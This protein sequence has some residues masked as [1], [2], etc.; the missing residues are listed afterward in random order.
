MDKSQIE[1]KLAKRIRHII[2][3]IEKSYESICSYG[4][5]VTNWFYKIL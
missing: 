1:R 5:D 4:P 2:K 3:K